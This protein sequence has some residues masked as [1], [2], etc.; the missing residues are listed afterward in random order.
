LWL[1]SILASV[2]PGQRQSWLLLALGILACKLGV[3]AL[4][5]RITS[6]RHVRLRELVCVP[7]KDV[8]I[9]CVWVAA[10]FERRI[11]WRGNALLIGPSSTITPCAEESRSAQ[12]VLRV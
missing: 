9:A 1:P 12:D 8:L 7:L 11:N 2:A 6:G 10:L 4:V 3:D 5:F